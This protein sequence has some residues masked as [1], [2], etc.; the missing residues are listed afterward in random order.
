MGKQSKSWRT[1]VDSHDNPVVK[2]QFDK[3]DCSL[4]S[5]RSKCTRSKKLPRL[6][7]LKPQELHLA[8]HDARIRQKTESFQQIY[9]QRAGVEGLISQA[10]GRYQLR[11]CRYIGLAK[12]LLQHVITAAAINFSRMWD[13]W[14]H[15]PRSQTRV[16][17]FARIAPTAS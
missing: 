14:Q 15:V 8:L 1:T 9:H 7:T 12:T 13:W 11:R 4:C 2:I 5:S 3:S 17:H 6:L 10:T 16:S